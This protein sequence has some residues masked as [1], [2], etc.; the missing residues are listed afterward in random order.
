MPLLSY[1]TMS[2]AVPCSL[3]LEWDI[4]PP[5][6]DESGTRAPVEAC[7]PSAFSPQPPY[8]GRSADNTLSF[9]GQFKEPVESVGSSFKNIASK[10]G[11][12]IAPRY[13]TQTNYHP[14][15]KR[16]VIEVDEIDK[17]AAIADVIDNPPESPGY[18]TQI[19][20][21][22]QKKT[23]IRP[24][25]PSRQNLYR[26][27]LPQSKHDAK[28]PDPI[29]EDKARTQE[30]GYVKV[31]SPLASDR[32]KHQDSMVAPSEGVPTQPMMSAETI[33]D[34]VNALSII[35]TY[36]RELERRNSSLQKKIE[37]MSTRL[38]QLE[39]QN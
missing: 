35:P 37:I 10:P 27:F 38:L 32:H 28:P 8:R 7:P 24:E 20:P 31:T 1:V 22:P 5:P 9:S 34:I 15:P 6:I 13:S 2:P 14:Y 39:K 30:I 36:V 23:C 17:V 4:G 18:V 12:M 19:S 3:K 33:Q 26:S 21:R 29:D 25:T 16:P 11:S